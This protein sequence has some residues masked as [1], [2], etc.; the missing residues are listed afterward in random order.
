MSRHRALTS[1][2]AMPLARICP[3]TRTHRSQRAPSVRRTHPSATC[4]WRLA[5]PIRSDLI[6]DRD[7]YPNG[8]DRLALRSFGCLLGQRGDPQRGDAVSIAAEHAEPKAVEG[9]GLTR[10]RNQLRFMDDQPG[11][12]SGFVV[13]Q[14]PVHDAVEVTDRHAPFYDNR[15]VRVGSYA[16]NDDIM[17]IRNIADEFLQN[18]F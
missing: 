11:D 6:Y 10:F 17:L 5:S 13:G 18:V 9:E 4:S 12:G 8:S 16:W 2:T 3:W 7:G 14:V 15:A 1:I